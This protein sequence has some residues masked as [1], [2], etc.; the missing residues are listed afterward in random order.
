MTSF[1]KIEFVFHYVEYD[2][3]DELRRIEI[4]WMTY[5]KEDQYTIDICRNMSDNIL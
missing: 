4:D 2:S 1:F 5:E 3:L